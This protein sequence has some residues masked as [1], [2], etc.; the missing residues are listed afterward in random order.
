ML[1]GPNPKLR[2]ND[3]KSNTDTE[4]LGIQVPAFKTAVGDITSDSTMN[5]KDC[6]DKRRQ[7]GGA[8][9]VKW[10]GE[11]VLIKDEKRLQYKTKNENQLTMN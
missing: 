11:T 1:K 5:L 7:S 9:P 4:I 3:P 10:E 8:K 6:A 2:F